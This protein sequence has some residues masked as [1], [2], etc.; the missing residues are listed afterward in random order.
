LSRVGVWN[1]E[2]WLAVMAGALMFFVRLA[3][4]QE[5]DA[6]GQLGRDGGCAVR[7][8]DACFSQTG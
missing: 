2:H 4:L 3:P 8:A 6:D 1:D 5:L 7:L